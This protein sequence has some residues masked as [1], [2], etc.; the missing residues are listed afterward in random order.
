MSEQTEKPILDP[1]ERKRK[2]AR[3]ISV[4]LNVPF[5]TAGIYQIKFY[6]NEELVRFIDLPVESVGTPQ[7]GFGRMGRS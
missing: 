1:A 6:L 5:K 3:H 4:A 2:G 7:S